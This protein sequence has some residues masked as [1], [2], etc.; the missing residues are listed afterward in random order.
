MSLKLFKLFKI[1]PVS[2]AGAA[3]SV[4]KNIRAL[5]ATSANR[6]TKKINRGP[7]F[8]RK[9]V[10]ISSELIS[11]RSGVSITVRA[12]DCTASIECNRIFSILTKFR[13]HLARSA[14]STVPRMSIRLSQGLRLEYSVG[15]NSTSQFV[16]Q[17]HPSVPRS[18][19]CQIASNW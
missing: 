8:W 2:G 9:N 4:G 19:F 16:W 15:K 3:R 13:L 1:R 12:V 18:N 11:R 5:T 10:I 7:I 17:F 6:K 14:H